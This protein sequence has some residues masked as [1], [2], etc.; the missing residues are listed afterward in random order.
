MHIHALYAMATGQPLPRRGHA[1]VGGSRLYVWEGDSG[2]CTIST[3]TLE[4]FDVPSVTWEQPQVLQAASDMPDG[5][6]GIAVTTMTLAIPSKA[7]PVTFSTK[8]ATVSIYIV[9]STVESAIWD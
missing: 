1:A 9:N 2:S 5:L 6:Y 4:I 7:R 8:R 3:T